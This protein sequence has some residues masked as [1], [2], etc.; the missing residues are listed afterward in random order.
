MTNEL[1]RIIRLMI[2]PAL[3]AAVLVAT[4][5]VWAG[6]PGRVLT[7]ITGGTPIIPDRV[8]ETTPHDTDDPAIWVHPTNPGKSLIFGTDKNRDG[9]LYAFDLKGR[10]VADKCILHLKRPNNVDIEY[11]LTLA[12]RSV[13]IAAVTERFT[14]KLRVFSLPDM[15]PLDNGGFALFGGEKGDGLRAPMGIGLFKRPKDGAV[16]AIVSRKNGP[17]D[18]YL[19]QYRLYDHGGKLAAEKVREFGAFSGKNEIEAIAVDDA[20]GYVYYSDE[21]TG[22]RKYYADPEKRNQELALFGETGF[23]QDHEGIAIYSTGKGT[24]YIL[25]SDQA[26]NTFHLFLRQGSPDNPHHHPCLG[27]LRLSTEQSDGCEATSLPLGDA[28]PF[29]LFVAMS[30]DRTFQYYNWNSIEQKG[31]KILME[32]RPE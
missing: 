19:W 10:I 13:D 24:G 30:T 26:A 12:G 22:I 4:V 9:G 6:G 20:L 14:G 28:F 29:G 8:T 7:E 5:P 27:V 23:T 31:I 17:S 3:A 21:G 11:G 18:H 1:N 32:S 15:T 2:R 25:V 16:F